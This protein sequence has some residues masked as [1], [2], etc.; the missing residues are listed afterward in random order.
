[1]KKIV[2]LGSTG[3]IGTQT[4]DVI[5]A[6][7][8]EFQI[9]GLSAH[10]DA[11]LLQR[12]VR[13]FQPRYVLQT[14]VS[15]NPQEALMSLAQ[16]ADAD[17][18]VNALAGSVG[19]MPTYA[20]VQ[21]GK[22]IALANKESLV[23]AGELIMKLAGETG[24]QILPID[25]EPSA[26]WQCCSATPRSDI[27]KIILTASGGPF[28]KWK[29]E[30]LEKVTAV[31]AVKHPTWKMGEKVSIDSATLMNK[32][33]E[34]IETRWLFDIPPEKI[35]VVIHRQS[36]IHSL[37]QFTDGNTAAILSQPDMRI[38]ISYALFY[39]ARA[40]RAPSQ[41]DFSQLA[42]TFEKPDFSLFEGPKLAYEVLQA[43]G[44]LPAVFCIADEIAVRKFIAGE[45][46]FL[47]IYDFVKKALEK[48]Q[49]APLSME[50]LEKLS[51]R[52]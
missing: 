37:V 34:I 13:E 27:G 5:R 23:M 10:E 15:E 21:A 2:I 39:P 11:D 16:T 49:N 32:A 12:Q 40:K 18:I 44:I 30:E 48:I 35:D 22:T 26:I 43:G 31:Q 42:L 33:F 47:G 50:A 46:S 9:L 36:I 19:L 17:L 28:W 8:G 51:S 20:A 3:S 52:L 14:S 38:P 6:N 7:Q 4:L 24:A 29:R 45:I 1:M 25:S 41:L